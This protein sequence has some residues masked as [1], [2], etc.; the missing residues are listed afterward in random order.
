MTDGVIG[1]VR[2][3]RTFSCQAPNGAIHVGTD[4]Q[5]GPC[6][7]N[8]TVRYGSVLVDSLSD[9]WS[10]PPAERLRASTDVGVPGPGCAPC[11]VRLCSTEGAPSPA[12]FYE[13]L[14][15]KEKR[16]TP[17][18]L[19]I[20]LDAGADQRGPGAGVVDDVRA[21]A[22]DLDEVRLR[23]DDVLLTAAGRTI[24]EVL[25]SEDATPTV[26]IDTKL[27][28]PP[29]WFDAVLEKVVVV[30][31]VEVLAMDEAVAGGLDPHRHPTVVPEVLTRL[32]TSA[33]KAGLKPEIRFSLRRENWGDLGALCRMADDLDAD[34]EVE[35]ATEPV[36][37]SV[38]DLPRMVLDDI[39]RSLLRQDGQLAPRLGP[40]RSA[41]RSTLDELRRLQDRPS[42][43]G[44]FDLVET[45]AAEAPASPIMDFSSAC[46]VLGARPEEVEALWCDADDVVEDATD[47]FVGLERDRCIGRPVV[48]V[49][50]AIDT[51]LGRRHPDRVDRWVDS[52]RIEWRVRWD[53]SVPIVVKGVTIPR[54]GSTGRVGTTTAAITVGVHE[55]SPTLDEL[56][57]DR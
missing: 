34:L 48:S 45:F 9:L 25:A 40:S 31:V 46:A 7:F 41:W 23:G 15:L 3:E 12:R 44:R 16:Q 27:A 49:F 36:R 8:A 53:T 18:R 24:L 26:W 28:E 4:G 20:D 21:W 57:R 19:D 54:Y 32:S 38:A 50:S 39:V 43:P 52:G 30:P 56:W 51:V 13:R 2:G 47:T 5:V 55:G 29:Q 22:P 6:P 35:V 42:Q 37:S 14:D 1:G 17:V 11:A 10:S 33:R